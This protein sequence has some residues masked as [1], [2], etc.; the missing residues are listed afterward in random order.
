MKQGNLACILFLHR[1][2]V[3]QIC[4]CFSALASVFSQSTL[5]NKNGT[6]VLFGP[7]EVLPFHLCLRRVV[8]DYVTN[9]RGGIV[10]VIRA[11]LSFHDL[12]Y[13]RLSSFSVT[14]SDNSTALA[15]PSI[16]DNSVQSAHPLP[17]TFRP[18]FPRVLWLTLLIRQWY[19]PLAHRTVLL[20]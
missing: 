10:C 1:L 20:G 11:W 6:H 13:S 12:N 18:L 5:A 16:G 8:Y 17:A 4:S 15:T 7:H 3:I 2:T 9:G 14:S 19:S